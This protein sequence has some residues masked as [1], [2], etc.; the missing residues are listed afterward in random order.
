[1]R[2]GVVLR[3]ARPKDA[4]EIVDVVRCGMPTDLLGCMIYG[5]PGIARFV[6]HQIEAGGSGSDTV[7]AVARRDDRMIGCAEMRVFP[8]ALFLNYI[9]VRPEAR[10]FGLGKRLFSQA[11]LQSRRWGQSR[12]LLDV[13]EKNHLARRWY[14]RMGFESTGAADWWEVAMPAGPG[15][16]E[17]ILVNYPQA[18]VAQSDFGFSVFELVSPLG[19]YMVGRLGD[20]WFRLSQAGALTDPSVDAALARIDSK[21]RLLAV[22]SNGSLPEM[23]QETARPLARSLRLA[24][25]FDVLQEQ[26]GPAEEAR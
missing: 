7:Y 17:A 19:R 24:I 20:E 21:R 4:C 2:T 15:A 26:L 6:K 11:L 10:D 5:C 9:S 22:L 23:L 8:D 3:P 18:Q 13:L 1:M 12:V 16:P 14:Q 25:D